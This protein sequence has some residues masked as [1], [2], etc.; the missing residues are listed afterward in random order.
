MSSNYRLRR[1]VSKTKE[2]ELEKPLLKKIE[3]ITEK[4][5]DQGL[6]ILNFE[7]EVKNLK[8]ELRLAEDF[9]LKRGE[10]IQSMIG[11]QDIPH[12][13][14]WIE[15]AKESIDRI[16]EIKKFLSHI[17]SSEMLGGK[18]VDDCITLEGKSFDPVS[19]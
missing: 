7:K 9:V 4:N 5:D 3:T 2:L 13:L 12:A 17:I 1:I 16:D 6:A 8:E 10:V 15:K 14:K 18:R 19:Y 11:C